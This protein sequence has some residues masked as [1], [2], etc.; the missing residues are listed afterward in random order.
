MKFKTHN[1]TQI[2]CGGTGFVGEIVADYK[3]LVR[4]FGKPTKGDE[5]K[6]DAEWDL[7]FE[8]GTVATIYNWKNG[9]NYCGAS[10]TPKTQIRDW[11]IGGNDHKSVDMVKTAI[12]AAPEPKEKKAKKAKISLI[13]AVI[14]EIK[15]DVKDGDLTVLEELLKFIPEANLLQAL[16][17][18]QWKHYPKIKG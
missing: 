14:E 2:S 18:E 15:Q 10:G 9:K 6:V 13:D 1:E 4:I 12:A 8:D 17:E 16:P 7:Q 11:H 3:D 5:Y